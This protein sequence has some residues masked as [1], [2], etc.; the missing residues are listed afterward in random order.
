M[1]LTHINN[2]KIELHLIEIH[3][4]FAINYIRKEI[5]RLKFFYDYL[6]QQNLCSK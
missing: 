1:K 2:V 6:A 5:F 3:I 4:S